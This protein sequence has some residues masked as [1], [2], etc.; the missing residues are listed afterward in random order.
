MIT[1]HFIRQFNIVMIL[2][3]NLYDTGDLNLDLC[4]SKG[5]AL[6][7]MTRAGLNVPPGFIITTDECKKYYDN[8]QKLKENLFNEII[9]AIKNLE[10]DVNGY[11]GDVHNPLLV[12]A[13]SGA[14]VSMPGMMD[15]ILNLGLNDEIVD[16]LVEKTK[17][18][19]F[20]YDSY[21][22]L[23]QMYGNV[24]L[25]IDSQKF[26][27]PKSSDVIE[28]QNL[29]KL[30]KE[31]IMRERGIE[32]EQNVFKQLETAISAV[33]SSWMNDRAV[34]YRKIN[35]ISHDIGTAVIIQKM[36]FGNLNNNSATGV[37]FT[38]NPSTGGKSLYGEFLSNAQGEDIV[39]G[40]RTP[41]KIQDMEL[42]MPLIYKEIVKTSQ[43]L[44][45]I[46]KDMQDVEFT[47]EDG[48]LWILQSRSG[49]RSIHAS[50]RIAID[51]LN[52]GLISEKDA[53]RR[54]N[55]YELNKIFTPVII[56]DRKLDIIANGLPASFGVATGKAVF[57]YE[58]AEH[59][60]QLD[61]KFILIREDTSPDD[62]NVMN[63]AQGIL[64]SRGGMTSHAAV[65]ARGMGKCC[66]VGCGEISIEKDYFIT[67]NGIRI[68]SGDIITLDGSTGR[69][70]LGYVE[71]SDVIDLGLIQELLH[72]ADRNLGIEVRANAET[73]SDIKK[74][75]E[76]GVS[77]IGLCRTE[78][79]FFE[80]DRIQEFRK[81]I[82]A[83]SVD[84]RKLVLS[85]ILEMQRS[86]F[87]AIFEL[88]KNKP[89]NIRLLD[90]PLFEFLPR[91]E[92]EIQKFCDFSHLN[93]DVV[94]K[95]ISE[96]KEENGMLGHR[97]SRLGITYPEIFETQIEAIFSAGID[98]KHDN[99]EIML[100]MI[101]NEREIEFFVKMIRNIADKFNYKTYK[102]GTMI[103]T[104]SACLNADK[105]AK[106]VDYFSFGTNDL[107]QMTL[108]ISRSDTRNFLPQ[109][110]EKGIFE[111]DPFVVIDQNTVGK[112]IEIAIDKAKAVKKD[113]KLGVCGEHGGDPKSV[114]YFESLGINYVS[115]SPYRVLAAK[116]SGV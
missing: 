73:V 27:L 67:S 102:I 106:F 47:I 61:E 107:T 109:Y 89:V 59:L 76:F 75:L 41:Q 112:M 63:I 57:S 90:P 95:T 31:V 44:E 101:V 54:I 97:G 70:I 50:I 8:G 60:S 55:P 10:S 69:V 80:K 6:L 43:K 88:M 78:H 68:N 56:D 26:A 58:E 96:L 100:P 74:A 39:S 25:G 104:P 72:I 77:G 84:E 40:T 12:S 86:D 53:I 83:R 110:L 30:N 3:F 93:M 62:I 49:K 45:E 113:I 32:F 103:E 14:K 16:N 1:F 22:R 18:P 115:C 37:L 29:I 38:R 92:D 35:H 108:G 2:S 79:M 114:Q 66:I 28:L 24:A 82:F 23:I 52:E 33:F 71:T 13:R 9:Q 21:G 81:L 116:L 36:V 105:I 42:Q 94:V 19:K 51:M 98:T 85:K 34:Y 7:N 17:N 111:A 15:T 65:V 11:Y 48:R 4:G 87:S 5:M 91:T 64:T 20:V 46:Y 99:I